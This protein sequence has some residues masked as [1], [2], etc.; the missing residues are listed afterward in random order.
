[1]ELWADLL[2]DQQKLATIEAAILTAPSIQS[3]H[4]QQRQLTAVLNFKGVDYNDISMPTIIGYS[5]DDLFVPPRLAF[6]LKQHIPHAKLVT[7]P[8]G[9][10]L[11][12]EALSEFL[13]LMQQIRPT[14]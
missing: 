9:H 10:G 12:L 11:M 4:D 2:E 3:T 1:M 13:T 6:S 14:S 7:F 5:E 8:G